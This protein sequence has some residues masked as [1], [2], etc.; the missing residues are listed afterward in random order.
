MPPDSTTTS[1]ILDDSP[2]TPP[3][4]TLPILT[5]TP[6]SIISPAEADASCAS[7]G[8]PKILAAINRL[9]NQTHL[10]TAPGVSILLT[11]FITANYDFGS[12]YAR[13]RQLWISPNVERAWREVLADETDITERKARA[14]A[15]DSR[16]NLTLTAPYN[17]PPRRMWDLHSN[18][19]VPL[20]FVRR[21]NNTWAITHS[22]QAT[23]VPVMTTVNEYEWPVPLPPG[24][25]LEAVRDEM[26]RLGAEYVWLDVVCTRQKAGRGE[27][28]R[29]AEWAVDLP[30]MGNV[31]VDAVTV[32]RYY[33]GLGC[34]FRADGL[35]DSK[36]WL[37]RAWTLQE[38][39]SDTRIGGLPLVMPPD[40]PFAPVT[41]WEYDA[42]ADPFP[43]LSG[44]LRPL[45]NISFGANKLAMVVR[46]M[47]HRG[48]KYPLDQ[49][50]G[51]GYLIRAPRLPVYNPALSEEAA[52]WLLI[53]C[54]T[55]SMRGELL[56]LFTAAGTAGKWYPEW[57]QL[58]QGD[59]LQD[60]WLAEEVKLRPN[61]T[62]SYYGRLLERC[63]VDGTE[64]VVE[65]GPKKD[66]RFEFDKDG[67]PP[68]V[69]TLVGNSQ[70]DYF[71]VCALQVETAGVLE[72]LC[73]VRLRSK[74][75]TVVLGWK[76]A[77]S[78]CVFG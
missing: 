9:T 36:H 19:V 43:E 15:T 73:V 27:A 29:E 68:G 74:A 7:L 16:G 3:S 37:N 8:L 33:T 22:W 55:N 20:H 78:V 46:E 57:K 35:T 61:G 53:E 26:L 75:A 63:R 54:M 40:M 17:L 71:V 44:R 59:M 18:R 45:A 58:R 6:T 12:A 65:T 69:Y 62:V 50:Y 32:V 28:L 13:L 39:K 70:A 31:Y 1:P 56:F 11:S 14:F 77:R 24:V 48:S 67:P 38:L 60:Q 42:D 30:T 10:L 72:K 4:L 23:L 76:L 25:T 64:V 5:S 34:P 49:I 47:Q 52:W 41:G 66:S 21:R 2:G 51:M